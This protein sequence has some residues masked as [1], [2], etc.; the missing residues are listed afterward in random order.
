MVN[1]PARQGR[2]ALPI[3]M[4]VERELTD[5]DIHRLVTQPI[6]RSA[7]PPLQRLRAPHHAAARLVAAGKSAVEVGILVGRTPQRINDLKNDPAFKELVAYYADQISNSEIADEAR[8]RHK[9]T[10]LAE[11]AV[12]E[13]QERIENDESRKRLP[14]SELRQIAELGLDRTVAPPKTAN[15]TTSTPPQ[16]TFNIGG[17]LKPASVP[18]PVAVEVLEHQPAPTDDDGA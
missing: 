11:D 18:P 4:S 2:I 15:T 14:A 10:T 5:A 1:I 17:A 13:L 7:A 3:V 9:L 16:I 6:E 8:L 12:D